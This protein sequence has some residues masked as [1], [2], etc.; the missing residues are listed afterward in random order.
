[1]GEIFSIDVSVDEDDSFFW[2][3]NIDIEEHD[4]NETLVGRPGVVVVFTLLPSLDHN[5]H[6][7][8]DTF[9]IFH[10]SLKG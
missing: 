7:S 5:D 8:P 1:V 4:P 2:S 6:M 9:D 10:V 3:N